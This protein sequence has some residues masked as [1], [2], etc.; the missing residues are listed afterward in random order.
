MRAAALLLAVALGAAPGCVQLG[1]VGDGTSVSWGPANR[2]VLLDGVQL[3]VQG[4][5]YVVLP[6]WSS[7]GTQWGVDELITVVTWTARAVAREHPGTVLAVGDMSIDGGGRSKHHASHRTGRDVDFVLFG[8]K[9]GKPLPATEMLPY[10]ADGVL[11]SDPTVSF[12]V[13]RE[14]T[15]VRALLSAPGPGIANIFLYAPL[16]VRLLD[17]ARAK[18]EPEGLIDLA[19]ATISQPGDSAP[20]NDHMHVRI[21]C[22][23]GEPTCRD[24]ALRPQAKKPP[25]SGALHALAA[26]VAERPIVG[27]LLRSR[28]RW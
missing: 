14:W 3:P 13:D 20:H 11:V 4:D 10:N 21:Y 28:P 25:P 24:Y 5:G 1:V 7:R 15:V 17:Y 9:D 19:A 16:R 22:P 2:G 12:D 8:V 6:T 27:G 18:G 23:R 26:V